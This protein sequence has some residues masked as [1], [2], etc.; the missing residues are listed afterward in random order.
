MKLNKEEMFIG[1]MIQYPFYFMI[2][3]WVIVAMAASG[4]LWAMGGAEKSSKLFRR[5]GCPIVSG[6]C[7]LCSHLSLGAL[8]GTIMGFG[9]LTI[10]YGESSW[11]YKRF[12]ENDFVIRTI[13]YMLYWTVFVAATLIGR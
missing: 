12:K 3:W 9:V 5:I 6:L 10:G 13:T 8:L 4:V 7:L 11:L 1:A 2:H